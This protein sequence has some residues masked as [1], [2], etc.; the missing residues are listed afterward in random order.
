[1]EMVVLFVTRLVAFEITG[2]ISKP[3]NG[4]GRHSRKAPPLSLQY[5][6]IMLITTLVVSFLVC[7]ML[8]VRCG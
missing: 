7:L 3:F 6:T 1:M 5:E 4:E 2:R 8:D